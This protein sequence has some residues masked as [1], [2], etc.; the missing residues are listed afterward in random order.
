MN[1]VMKNSQSL[2]CVGFG[3]NDTHLQGILGERLSRGMPAVLLARTWTKN[4]I[5][6]LD[7]YPT[8][9]GIQ[10]SALGSDARLGATVAQLPANLWSLD[11]FLNLFLE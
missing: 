11:E 4:A 6:I 9:L 10:M 5:A 3:F 2:F 8:V 1:R 7:R